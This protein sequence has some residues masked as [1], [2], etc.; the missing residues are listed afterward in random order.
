LQDG[1]VVMLNPQSIGCQLV[2]HVIK[3]WNKLEPTC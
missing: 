2:C 1:L 3:G